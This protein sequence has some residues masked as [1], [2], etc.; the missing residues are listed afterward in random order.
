MAFSMPFIAKVRSLLSGQSTEDFGE[1]RR[2]P[3][4][5]DMRKAIALQIAGLAKA[6]L[7]DYTFERRRSANKSMKSDIVI[8]DGAGAIVL[9][10][11]EIEGGPLAFWS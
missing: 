2:F 9:H 8:Y 6:D 4:T 7:K 10:G 5:N 1:G 11:R 3:L